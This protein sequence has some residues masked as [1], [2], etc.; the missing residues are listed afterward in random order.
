MTSGSAWPGQA[1]GWTGG[2]YGRC[3]GGGVGGRAR[4]CCGDGGGRRRAG[5]QRCL[6]VARLPFRPQGQPQMLGDERSRRSPEPDR[7]DERAGGD[8]ARQRLSRED[9]VSCRPPPATPGQ[10][11]PSRCPPG[12]HGLIQ[13]EQSIWGAGL[14]RGGGHGARPWA[15]LLET[16]SAP[17]P[18]APSRSPGGGQR[19][20]GAVPGAVSP[21][22]RGC[23]PHALLTPCSWTPRPTPCP[24][25][26]TV[27]STP[28]RVS[29]PQSSGRGDKHPPGSQCP[30]DG[31]R[32]GAPLLSAVLSP[33][34]PPT[35][36]G[37]APS[38]SLSPSPQWGC[39]LG[40]R[41]GG[42][43]DVPLVSAELVQGVREDLGPDTKPPGPDAGTRSRGLQTCLQGRCRRREG[44]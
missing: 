20:A 25:P 9:V 5:G 26:L 31:G 1:G 28:S 16:P 12:A 2:T 23:G 15:S 7:A 4:P 43:R 22:C 18:L 11:H 41:G 10:R 37:D 35:G 8:G 38:P 27:G 40:S 6:L 29:S 34:P 13:D 19:R 21:G 39:H 3:P 24:S 33:S 17:S 44:C 42:C 36:L 32:G 14:W 30:P